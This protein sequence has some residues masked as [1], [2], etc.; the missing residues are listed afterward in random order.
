MARM[1]FEG[2]D[3]LIRETERAGQEMGERITRALRLASDEI[4]AALQEEER[5]TFKAP[6]GEMGEILARSPEITKGAGVSFL[7][8]YPGGDYV[9]RG[10]PR[11]AATIAFVLEAGRGE[12]MPANPWNARAAK[13]YKRRVNSI[14][15]D[16]LKGG[17]SHEP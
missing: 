6:T 2:Y 17:G 5:T 7:E 15:Q 12:N 14:I 4:V 1:V 3:G 16:T 8:V 11:R 10:R 9:G 13:K